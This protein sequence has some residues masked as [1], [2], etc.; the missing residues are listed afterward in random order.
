MSTFIYGQ[1]SRND[2]I[3]LVLNTILTDDIGEVDV[4][5]S[6]NSIAT[7][8]E[9]IDNDSPSNPYLESWVFFSDDNPFASWYHSSRII[10]V[11]T[12]DGSYTISNVEIYPKELSSDY[13]EISMADRP[14]PVA[15][16][17]TAFVPDPQKVESN[18]NYALIIVSMDQPRNWYNT[19]LI[20]SVLKQNYNYKDENIFVL[21]RW[22]GNSQ[23]GNNLDG[24]LNPDD[25][26]DGPATWATIQQVIAEMKGEIPDPTYVMEALGHGD[27]LAVFFTGV[28]IGYTGGFYKLAFWEIINEEPVLVK[29]DVS[30]V[31]VPMEDIDCG[32]MIFTFDINSSSDISVYFEGPIG[33]ENK[34]LNRYLHGSTDSGEKNYAEMYFSGGNRYSEQLFYWASAARGY[35]PEIDA[36]WNIWIDPGTGEPIPLGEENG[37]F[38]YEDFI[39]GH[40]GDFYL[41]VDE[42][43]FIQ[44]GEAF[45]YGSI[46]N[47]WTIDDCH[48]PPNPFL[49]A[50]HPHQT[51][52]FPFVEDL[53]TLAGLSGFILN[54]PQSIPARSY[55]IADSVVVKEDLNITLNFADNTEFY[56]NKNRMNLNTLNYARFY[57][58][59]N[60]QAYFGKNT[61]VTTI[62]PYRNSKLVFTG[63]SLTIG[64]GSLF[65]WVDLS[66]GL[67]MD[68]NLYLNNV[69]FKNNMV[70]TAH[71]DIYFENCLFRKSALFTF[72]DSVFVINSTFDRSNLWAS[73]L[74][75]PHTTNYI[76]IDSCNF[77]GTNPYMPWM[78]LQ[79]IDIQ[80]YNDY[81]IIDNV[82]DNTTF[83]I[84][85]YNS[86]WGLTKYFTNNEVKFI[87]N[88]G[89]TINS[90]NIRMDSNYIHNNELS[91]LRIINHSKVDLTGNIDAKD[92]D[93]TQRIMDNGLYEVYSNSSGFPVP[94]IWNAIIDEDN[95]SIDDELVYCDGIVYSEKDVRHNYWGE[96]FNAEQ[97]FYP[98]E[99]YIW[100]PTFDL[101]YDTE[102][103]S[104]AQILYETAQGK[105]EAEDY[106]GAKNDYQQVVGLYPDTRYAQASLKELYAIEKYET[107]DYNALKQYYLTDS[108][109]TGDTTLAKTG[110]FLSNRCNIQLQNWPDA[111]TWFEN[112]IQYPPSFPDS[113]YAI[114]DLGHTY[115]LMQNGGNKSSHYTGS[116]PQ[117]VP[118]SIPSHTEY[119]NY[120]LS[121]LPGDKNQKPIVESLE[122]LKPG[123]LL[124]NVP[125]PFNYSTQIWYKLEKEA[126][127]NIS[128]FDYTGKCIKTL[129]C[130][131]EE[132]GTHYIDFTSE[133][134]S[135][136]IYF[137]SLE[138]NGRLTDSKK[139]TII[140]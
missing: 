77:S 80:Y 107:N 83:G 113:I 10:Y 35:L 74:P 32:Q 129:N 19:S 124:Q 55:I 14:D 54:G 26:I 56:I 67:N 72:S 131:A 111:I 92:V 16:D 15:M 28:P 30:L 38:P 104:D 84:H 42:D 119:T 41:D 46:L 70:H 63:N 22:D 29:D 115:L 108:I 123:E 127:V 76:H 24:P 18:Y 133:G 135:A 37:G 112:V 39:S 44:M 125:N 21:Y 137:Y 97:D 132:E 139:M 136:G 47:T 96:N 69:T 122:S 20:Y 59:N 130:G 138:V 5:A 61:F 79:A 78:L 33:S 73:S 101:T 2:A 82:I 49:P 27:Q 3:D 9:L 31:S 98:S 75:L 94:F 114:I 50:P 100:Y 120:L 118:E 109:I 71:W 103:K 105:A 91:G 57:F 51:D 25:D 134:L 89:V 102:E 86:G 48:I 17:G 106:T 110:D 40:P 65:N 36:P 121:L 7:D 68:I 140:R 53:I 58:K 1:F 34:C 87:L 88:N 60:T 93:E 43:T 81:T 116:M 8:V 90:S 12:T 23:L 11:S 126:I 95:S 117:Y 64:Q 13:E 6:Y 4:Y 52:E 66:A 99:A 128:V 85:M 45:D 62:D